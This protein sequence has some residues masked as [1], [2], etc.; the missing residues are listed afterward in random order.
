MLNLAPELPVR[1]EGQL[2]GHCFSC[3]SES[4]IVNGIRFMHSLIVDCPV[5]CSDSRFAISVLFVMSM[6]T[7]RE[8]RKDKHL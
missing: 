2:H 5:S 8:C 6:R 3:C 4:L 1:L 7:K